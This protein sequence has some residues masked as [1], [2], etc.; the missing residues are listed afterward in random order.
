MF[1]SLTL[2]R[3]LRRTGVPLTVIQKITRGADY[4]DRCIFVENLQSLVFHPKQLLFLEETHKDKN[5]SRHR[6]VYSFA[7]EK[8]ELHGWFKETV[9]YTIIG[10]TIFWRFVKDAC[11]IICRILMKHSCHL[12]GLLV[13]LTQKDLF[14]LF[15]KH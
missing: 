15:K 14:N 10:V 7:K 1:Y 4:S 13:P 5:A 8:I 11:N 9:R 2:C 6:R 12:R 3:N